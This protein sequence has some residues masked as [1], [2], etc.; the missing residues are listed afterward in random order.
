MMVLLHCRAGFMQHV[1]CSPRRSHPYIHTVLVIT[2]GTSACATSGT[3]TCCACR[4][5]IDR[6]NVRAAGEASSQ[7][8]SAKMGAEGESVPFCCRK[9]ICSSK[10]R[11]LQVAVAYRITKRESKTF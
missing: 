3:E 2:A 10:H 1:S 7:Q 9:T 8:R 11:T 6:S 5:D 4:L